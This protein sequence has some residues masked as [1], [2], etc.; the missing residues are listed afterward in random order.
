MLAVVLASVTVGAARQPPPDQSLPDLQDLLPRIRAT[1]RADADLF[2]RYRY[3]QRITSRE[4]GPDGAIVRTTVRE[5]EVRPNAWGAPAQ[6]V[7]LRVDGRPVPRARINESRRKNRERLEGSPEKIARWRR[8]AAEQQAEIEKAIDEVFRT[9]DARSVGR[10]MRNGH[11]A[12]EIAFQPRPDADAT[13]SIGKL[14]RKTRGRVWVNETDGQLIR[15]EGEAIETILY[16]WGVVARVH[17]GTRLEFERRL[18]DDEAWLPAS[19]LLQGSARMLLF[20]VDRFDRQS[21]F[22]EYQ[23]ID[24]TATASAR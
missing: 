11:A 4:R 16:G 15:F 6:W 24:A 18:V 23:R 7:L 17:A 2:S 5:Y 19:Y 3:R 22:F 1:L 20:K 14:F 9:V 13:T 12:I 21:E 8:A 10:V